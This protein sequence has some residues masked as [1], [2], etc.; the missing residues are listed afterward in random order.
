MH[1]ALKLYWASRGASTIAL[2]PTVTC[3]ERLSRSTPEQR[4]CMDCRF[5]QRSVGSSIDKY[6]MQKHQRVS[7]GSIIAG[8]RTYRSAQKLIKFHKN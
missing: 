4:P 6:D 3:Y 7:F 5:W 2:A 1:F 8:M